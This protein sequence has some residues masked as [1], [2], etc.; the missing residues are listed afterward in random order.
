MLSLTQP[1]KL[2]SPTTIGQVGDGGIGHRLSII[3]SIC[4]YRYTP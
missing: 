4:S 3:S 1:F 2:A